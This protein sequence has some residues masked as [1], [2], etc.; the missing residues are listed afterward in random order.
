[1]VGKGSSPEEIPEEFAQRW[2]DLRDA[3]SAEFLSRVEGDSE[4]LDPMEKVAWFGAMDQSTEV[5]VES[6]GEARKAG[7][8]WR[9]IAAALGLPAS[10]ESANRTR[11]RFG[12][13][14]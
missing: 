6:I 5:L 8:S 2:A 9:S 14:I 7:A 12:S 1:M 3:A 10:R 13:R 4:N 11:S